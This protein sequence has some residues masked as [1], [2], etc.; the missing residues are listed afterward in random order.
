MAEGY[1]GVAQVELPFYVML[2]FQGRLY[3]YL[4]VDVNI[5]LLMSGIEN[6][7]KTISKKRVDTTISNT[8]DLKK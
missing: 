3:F 6:F 4:S 5:G 1:P 2:R 8:A 7:E